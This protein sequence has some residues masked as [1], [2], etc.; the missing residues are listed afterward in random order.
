MAT[1]LNQLA[2]GEKAVIAGYEKKD[3]R[4]REKLLSMGLTKGTEITLV[5][6]A[7]LGDPV[8]IEVRGFKLSLRKEE[9]EIL[10][11]EGGS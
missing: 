5:K 11:L 6:Y 9:A 1:K 4:Y 7:P 10:T 2:I 3:Q 8:E